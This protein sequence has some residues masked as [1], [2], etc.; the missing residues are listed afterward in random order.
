MSVEKEL[1]VLTEAVE[2]IRTNHLNSIYSRLGK[3]EGGVA[4][5]ILLG[6]EAFVR[7]FL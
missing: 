6:I 1:K 2:N 3:V 7:S 5:L 4:V